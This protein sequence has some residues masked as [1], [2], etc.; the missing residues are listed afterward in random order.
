MI[1][2]GT[3]K[4]YIA[5]MTSLV[6]L[7][8]MACTSLSEGGKA[9]LEPDPALDR[10]VRYSTNRDAELRKQMNQQSS[11]INRKRNIEESGQNAPAT[12]PP[13]LRPVQVPKAPIDSARQNVPQ[14]LPT[15]K[16]GNQ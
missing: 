13:M 3:M 1:K 9:S 16:S 12:V 2:M 7:G 8:L 11:D 5:S 10:R 6:F 14:P 4:K 15:R